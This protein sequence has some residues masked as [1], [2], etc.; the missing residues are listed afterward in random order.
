MKLLS[1][2]DCCPA[3][4]LVPAGHWVMTQT[5]HNLLFAHVPVAPESL[6]SLVPPSIEIDTFDG[7]AWLGVVAF[8]LS[9]IR[10]HGFPEVGLVSHFNEI[11]LRTYVTQGGK[12]GV[13]FLSMDADNRL[14]IALARPTFRLP[15]TSADISFKRT[16]RGFSF[17]GERRDGPG[18]GTQFKAEYRPAGPAYTAREGTLDHWLTERYCY[19]CA[20]KANTYRC[21]I[22][23]PPWPLQRACASI[24][25]NPLARSL[26]LLPEYGAPLLHY[27]HKMTALIWM[28]RRL[29]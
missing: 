19:Y 23:H 14:A 15:Y 22:F 18:K 25:L 9:K 1:K 3:Q 17:A 21:D 7:R 4:V 11:N 20:S 24:E 27:A 16:S 29:R 6:R 5:W 8:R 26:G 13:L 12:P 10:L 28:P 2:S